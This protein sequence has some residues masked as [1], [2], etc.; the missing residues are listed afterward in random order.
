MLKQNTA[1]K[2]T[3]TIKD[4]QHTMNTTQKKSQAIPIKSRGGL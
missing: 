1:N 4:T 2:A 3:K